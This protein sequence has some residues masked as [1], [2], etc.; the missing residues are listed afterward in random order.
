[1]TNALMIADIVVSCVLLQLGT[2]LLN[3]PSLMH[4]LAPMTKGTQEEIFR[5]THI[6]TVLMAI[7]YILF[8]F[9]H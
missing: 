4:Y 8:R 5:F 9:E 3:K 2:I 7:V 6:I 1:M